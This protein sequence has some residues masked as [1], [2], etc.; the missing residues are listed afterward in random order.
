LIDFRNVRYW[1][2]ADIPLC[3][4]HV[5]FREQ[6]GHPPFLYGARRLRK[7]FDLREISTSRYGLRLE[8]FVCISTPSASAL[9][10]DV[11]PYFTVS[12]TIL[13]APIILKSRVLDAPQQAALSTISISLVAA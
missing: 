8:N 6:S 12:A 4:A 13:T 7:S 1:H 2:K 11:S 3:T 5:R 10:L 9:F